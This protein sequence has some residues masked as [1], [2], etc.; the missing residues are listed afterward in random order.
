MTDHSLF[1]RVDDSH[2]GETI[3]RLAIGSAADALK[4]CGITT[5]GELFQRIEIEALGLKGIKGLDRD[6][7]AL[8]ADRLNA[9]SNSLDDRGHLDWGKFENNCINPRQGERA[10]LGTNQQNST[11]QP[12]QSTFPAPISLI[13]SKEVRTGIEFIA[14]FP[15]AIDAVIQSRTTDVDRLILTERLSRDPT[16]RKT[17]EGV[18]QKA[19]SKITRERI[20][21]REQKLIELLATALLH[22]R[23]KRLGVHFHPSFR[24]FWK[25]AA[26]AFSQSEQVGF[27]EFIEV[28]TSAWDVQADQLVAHLPLILAVLTRKSTLPTAIREQ[29]KLAPRVLTTIEDT[30]RKA[31]LGMLSLGKTGSRLADQGLETVGDLLDAIKQGS[32]PLERSASGQRVQQSLGALDEAIS[33]SGRI[34]WARYGTAMGLPQLPSRLPS[35][36]AEFIAHLQTDIEE[37]L[38]VNNVTLRALDIF[39]LRIAVLRGARPTLA[40]AAEKLHTHGPSIKREESVLLRVLNDLLVARDFTHSASTFSPEFLTY[41]REASEVFRHASCDFTAFSEAL[42]ERWNLQTSQLAEAGEVL[43][44]VLNEYPSGRTGRAPPKSSASTSRSNSAA[45]GGVIVLRGF[46]RLH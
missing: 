19:G 18:A 46:R 40:Q 16:E 26:D 28:L 3:D 1:C 30:D 44:A 42:T 43:W 45:A 35:N 4:A 27:W 8:I 5:I 31:P 38:R 36:P 34:D 17:L 6:A 22:G 2:F 24:D 32:V 9:V 21:Q 12:S 23:G 10:H 33:D 41:W 25:Q 13:P 15:E 7:M 11:R 20:R 37:I 29:M 14:S 39:R